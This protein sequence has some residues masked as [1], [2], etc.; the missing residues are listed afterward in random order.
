MC[1][2]E[3]IQ[4]NV[5]VEDWNDKNGYGLPCAGICP[6]CGSNIYQTTYTDYCMCGSQ[7]YVY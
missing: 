6:D 1:D 4:P 2:N 5:E 7:D 3:E